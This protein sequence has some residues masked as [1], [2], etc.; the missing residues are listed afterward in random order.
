LEELW[1]RAGRHTEQGNFFQALIQLAAANLKLFMGNRQAAQN[2]LQRGLIRLQ[3]M[4]ESYMGIDVVHL[5]KD[6]R[7]RITRSHWQAPS[8]RLVMPDQETGEFRPHG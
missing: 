5:T 8:L 4:P 7:Q 6:L 1:N 3:R 2:L